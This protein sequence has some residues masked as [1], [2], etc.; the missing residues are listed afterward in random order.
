MT[1]ENQP[2][3]SGQ[4]P[5]QGPNPKPGDRRPVTPDFGD[6]VTESKEPSGEKRKDSD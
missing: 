3:D 5:P 6:L 2:K 1:D 4:H